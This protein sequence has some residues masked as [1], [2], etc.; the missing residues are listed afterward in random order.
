MKISY[1]ARLSDYEGDLH[2][3]VLVA[4]TTLVL[5]LAFMQVRAF[6]ALPKAKAENSNVVAGRKA[7]DAKD[8]K[9]AV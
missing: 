5:G 3:K 9:S 7:I 6:A 2:M 1:L 4:L 8:F